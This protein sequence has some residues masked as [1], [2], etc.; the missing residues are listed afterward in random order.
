MG[1]KDIN[2]IKEMDYKSLKYHEAIWNKESQS[3]MPGLI[4]QAVGFDKQHQLKPKGIQ[5]TYL[6]TQTANKENLI[7]P[8]RYAG[9]R[10]NAIIMIQKPKQVDNKWLIA[11][12][13]ESALSI[14][15]S[16]PDI[17]VACLTSL[18]NID[19]NPLN[20]KGNNLTLCVNHETPKNVIDRAGK[21]FQD[22]NFKV[23][24]AIPQTATSFS[25][26]LKN[27]GEGAV[28]E[29][30]NNAKEMPKQ[31]QKNQDKEIEIIIN[32]FKQL[33]EKL[34][35]AQ[36]KNHHTYRNHAQNNIEEYTLKIAENQR[37]LYKLQRQSPDL[38]QRV[39]RILQ[40]EK[41]DVIER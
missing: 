19:K 17:R 9:E 13:I 6:N 33:D 30:L 5:I 3:H 41:E 40:K 24:I 16:N 8:V 1:I 37:L 36:L 25:V 31:H 4:A 7:S 15:K 38:Y 32:D 23:S 39:S 34:E 11:V 22:K 2:D 29:A 12:D 21:V 27:K 10:D 20:G 35:E 28:L 18:H 14:A 26:L